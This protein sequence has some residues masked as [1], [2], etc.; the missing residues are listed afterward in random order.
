MKYIIKY[1]INKMSCICNY[2]NKQ[3]SSVSNLNNHIKR[4]KYCMTLRNEKLKCNHCNQICSSQQ[5]FDVHENLCS[6]IAT[7]KTIITE[8]D[9]II[10]N[11]Q[12]EL[13]KKDINIDDLQL[14]LKCETIESELRTTKKF[15]EKFI[16]LASRP[17]NKTVNKNKILIQN[18]NPLTSNK[19]SD[20]LNKLNIDV[21][22]QGAKGYANWAHDEFLQDSA[23]CTDVSRLTLK[24]KDENN[25]IVK[26]P[27][28]HKL[29]EKIFKTIETENDEML[30]IKLK[31]LVN[32]M[33]NCEEYELQY[34]RDKFNILYDIKKS[35][36]K[37]VNGE[38]CKFGDD[39]SRH[40]CAKL[41]SINEN[42]LVGDC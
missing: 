16:E 1:N 29:K 22:I 7:L 37:I 39:F 12:C 25:I 20:S 34:I 36:E 15:T 31:D 17:T 2:C 10:E 14:K 6:T 26:D 9:K 42:K 28:C 35:T 8:K 33:Q 13:Y 4:T 38:E 24:Y 41:G 23:V 19:I 11:L 3:F 5:E 30:K 40:L 27:K 18:L 21:A 32:E